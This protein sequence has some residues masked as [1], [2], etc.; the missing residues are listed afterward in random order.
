M[1]LTGMRK[2]VGVLETA[3]LV[4]TEKVGRVRTCRI[5]PR[6]LEEA[7]AWIERYQQVWEERF[8][9]LDEVIED[10][11]RQEASDGRD[12]PR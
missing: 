9:Q 3:G 12:Q 6:R 10:L 1:S 7:A 11:K 2:H 5:G 4:V 8:A